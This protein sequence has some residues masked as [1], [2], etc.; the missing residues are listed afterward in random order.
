MATDKPINGS[1]DNTVILL[2]KPGSPGFTWLFFF[3]CL[4][5]VAVKD[6][7]CRVVTCE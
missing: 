1:T 3:V 6:L 7:V 4:G 2:Q 5:V